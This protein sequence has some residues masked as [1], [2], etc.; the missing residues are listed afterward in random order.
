MAYKALL[1]GASEY[2]DPA[3][4]A[5]PFVRDDLTLLQTVLSER[6]FASA[7][8]LESA[9]GITRTAVNAR[10]SRFLREA[11]RG[12]CLLVLLS[13][14][15]QHFEGADYLIPEDASFAIEPFADC[16]VQIDWR[17]ELENSP[18]A[19]VVFLIDACRE[20]F[21]RDTK[22]PAGVRGWSTPK[23]AAALR[24]KAAH[25]YACSPAEVARYV[26]TSDR[27]ADHAAAGRTG[28]SFSLFSRAVADVVAGSEHA[29]D[30]AEFA[31]R[32]QSRIDDLHVA[33]GKP[34]TPQRIRVASDT[35]RAAFALLPGPARQPRAHPWLGLV[36]GHSAWER[37]APGPAREAVKAACAA[38][39]AQLARSFEDASSA[40]AED[41]WHDAEFA[42]R[43]QKRMHFLIG[44]MERTSTFSPTEAALAVLLP[45]VAEAFRVTETAARAHLLA[46]GAT[47]PERVRF[48][49]FV[50]THPRLVRRL[51]TLDRT[52]ERAAD[53]AGIRWWLFHRW[54]ALQP[55]V[56]GAQSLK[57]LLAPP[58]TPED[59]DRPDWIDGALSADRFARFLQARLTAPFA[60]V[61]EGAQEPR[62]VIAASTGDEH[63]VR[64]DLVLALAKA[65]HALAVSPADLPEIVVEHL[66]ISDNVGL[67]D[68]LATLRACEWHASGVGRSLNAACHHPA[69]QIA[70]REHAH[71]TDALLRDINRAPALVPL[72]ALPP[73]ADADLV[74]LTGNTPAHLSDGIRFQ[75]AEDRVQELLM[76]ESLYGNRKLAVREL[77]Q[78]ALDAVRYR[79][80]RTQYLTRTNSGRRLPPWTG[81]IT[82]RQ[83]VDDAGRPYL[84]CRDNGIGMGVHELSRTFAQGGARFVDLPEYVEEQAAWSA[85]DPKIELFPN[86]RFGIGVLSYFML[87]DEIVVHT[88]RMSRDGRPGRRLKV[89]I[90]GP[91]NLFRIEDVG[92]GDETGTSVRLLLSRA[93]GQVSCVDTLEE[94]LWVAQY[95]T[96]AVHA[97]RR[98]E[99]EPGELSERAVERH[100]YENPDFRDPGGG[101]FRSADPDLWWIGGRGVA[102]SDG[103][104]ADASRGPE[105]MPHGIVVNLHGRHRPQLSVDRATFQNFR[106]RPLEI[107]AVAVARSLVDG[108]GLALLNPSWLG[109]VGSVSLP[110]ADAIVAA[111]RGR[112]LPW[113]VNGRRAPLDDVGVFPPD[114]LLLP[115]L[116]PERRPADQRRYAAAYARQ[117]PEPILRWRLATLLGAVPADDREHAPRPGGASP[118]RPSDLNLLVTNWQHAAFWQ[119]NLDQWLRGPQ[120]ND[121]QDAR[122]SPYLRGTGILG[123]PHLPHWLR[124]H[125]PVPAR[126][127]LLNVW[128]TGMRAGDVARRMGELGYRTAP[129]AGAEDAGTDDFHLLHTLNPANPGERPGSA[130]SAAQISLS[131]LNADVPS[132]AA[133]KRLR[134][135]GFDVTDDFERCSGWSAEDRAV[136]I[137]LWEGQGDHPGQSAPDTVSVPQ[138]LNTA[139]LTGLPVPALARRLRTWGF[140][141]PPAGTYPDDLDD[142]DRALLVRENRV[143]GPD[144][145]VPAP[146][147]FAAAQGTGRSTAWAAQRLAELGFRIDP[148][149]AVTSCERCAEDHA[150]LLRAGMYPQRWAPHGKK[151]SAI[152][153]AE[154]ALRT[155]CS[156]AD[157]A[158]CVTRVGKPVAV[159]PAALAQLTTDD[160]TVLTDYRTPD[161]DTYDTITPPQIYAV[162]AHTGRSRSEI[163]RV[164]ADLGY[165]VA[166]PDED[167]ERDVRAER[168]LDAWLRKAGHGQGPVPPALAPLPGAAEPPP[169]EEISLSALVAV[170]LRLGMQLRETANLARALGLANEAADWFTPNG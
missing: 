45:L 30:L 53:A 112:D 156:A 7:E 23:I 166:P 64:H 136:L 133:A 88:C 29:M 160:L 109:R 149:S 154:A 86:S 138:L 78:N 110:L 84:E 4:S 151:I 39:A 59:P 40:L 155:D 144:T 68:L 139:A 65:A 94:V 6:G 82:F 57:M 135:L 26:R 90:A 157:I 35:D 147:V 36:A 137:Y 168:K 31:L 32:V 113:P 134:E 103:L 122:P 91:G 62:D 127:M 132:E 162:A 5:L 42:L 80:A 19:Q 71:R 153:L 131:A 21:E 73:F 60:V 87:A 66:G 111:A 125:D 167:F 56:Y 43:T 12:D 1:I 15:G 170:A 128:T 52:H 51:R 3:I 114:G 79:D 46:E 141:L 58:R 102:L 13:G 93:A 115:A 158:V 34:R 146:H 105:P 129:L 2:D 161:P 9:R 47:G 48:E 69:V 11:D 89:T 85:L 20:G 159:G 72:R 140:V 145:P 81:E 44:R 37:T 70:L 118:A 76:G 41:P 83:G 54:L 17:R 120:G 121:Y 117:I 104:F 33:Y 123:L 107:R 164:L 97:S 119:H 124:P 16:C 130:V 92:E 25:V 98:L 50:R 8:I 18:A 77:Y 95:R 142:D 24:R 101:V 96:T 61:P 165:D 55:D 148:E 28:D 108:G 116:T 14:H 169:P 126:T 10:V 22:S 106:R 143:P 100:W 150:L 38:L 75:L 99:W 163:T 67:P 27:A 152:S 49:D 74:R 63:E